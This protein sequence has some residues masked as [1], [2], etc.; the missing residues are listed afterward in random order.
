M[1]A[2]IFNWLIDYISNALDA[3][4]SLFLSAL[5]MSMESFAEAFPLFGTVYTT[6]QSIAIGLTVVVALVGL[7]TFFFTNSAD[8]HSF[9][10]NPFSVLVKAF[11]AGGMIYF[12]GYLLAAVTDVAKLSF[13]TLKSIDAADV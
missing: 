2:S 1:L 11:I 13:D 3:F 4:I 10:E 12:G 6:L 7:Y 8:T 5:D 9:Q